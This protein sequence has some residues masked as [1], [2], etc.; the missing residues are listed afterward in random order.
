MLKERVLWLYRTIALLSFGVVGC[1]HHAAEPSLVS[2]DGASDD[3]QRQAVEYAVRTGFKETPNAKGFK[4][5]CRNQTVIGTHFSNQV[6]YTPEQLAQMFANEDTIREK[7]NLPFAC[8]GS[9]T[10][11]QGR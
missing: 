4:T 6:C 7:L 5:Y 1:A 9:L 3:R 10:C 8:A 11:G 2:T